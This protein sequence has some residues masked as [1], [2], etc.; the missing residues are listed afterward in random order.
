MKYSLVTA[1]LLFFSACSAA[2]YHQVMVAESFRASTQAEHLAV[3]R[4]ASDERLHRECIYFGAGYGG[5]SEG[6]RYTRAPRAAF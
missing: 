4:Q 6:C 2:D 3:L 1:M 5:F